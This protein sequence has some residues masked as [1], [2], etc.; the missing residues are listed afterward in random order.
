MKIAVDYIPTV[1]FIGLLDYTED[2]LIDFI[3]DNIGCSCFRT[4][5]NDTLLKLN[6]RQLR[7]LAKQLDDDRDYLHDLFDDIE[8]CPEHQMMLAECYADAQR[9][10]GIRC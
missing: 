4:N 10:D 2:G 3:N 5:L 9:E 7:F 6:Y 8:D 1:E